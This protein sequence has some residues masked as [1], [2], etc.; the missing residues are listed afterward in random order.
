[1]LCPLSRFPCHLTSNELTILVHVG[2]VDLV[3]E[4]NEPLVELYGRQHNAV[5]CAAELAVMVKRLH[6]QLWCGGTGE[7]QAYHLHTHTHTHTME[8]LE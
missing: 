2:Q 4:E 5:G 7:V 8:V 3:T 6:Q 1:M